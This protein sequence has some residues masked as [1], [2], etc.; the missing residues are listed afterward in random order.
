M[1]TSTSPERRDF[2]KQS[3][4][5]ALSLQFAVTRPASAASPGAS[6]TAFIR[7]ETSGEILILS[8]TLEMGQGTHTAHAMIL[9][10]ELG[11]DLS[12]VRVQTATPAPEFGR[13]GANNTRSMNS[14][15]SWGVR[16][17]HQP[18]RVVGAQAREMLLAA[19]ATRWKVP[20]NDLV[21]EGGRVRH[22]ASGRSAGFGELAGLAASEAVPANPPLRAKE[23][24]RYSGRPV[25]RLDIPAKTNGSFIYGCDLMLPEMVYACARLSPVF[26]AE[27]QDFDSTDTLRTPG[28]LQVVPLPHGAAVVAKTTWAAM[29]GAG[30]LKLRWKEATHDGLSSATISERMRAGLAADSD[31]QVAKV[32]GD[33]QAAL[34]GA[35]WRVEADYEVPFIA[36][37]AME[38]FN[39]TVRL[40]RD[41]VEVWGPFQIQDRQ[42]ATVARAAG[43]APEQV[44]LHTTPAGGAFGRRFDD[45]E[46]PA[47]IAVARALGPGRPVKYFWRREEETHQGGY[48]P[49]QMARLRAGLDAQGKVVALQVRTCGTSILHDFVGAP[50]P[51]LDFTNVQTLGDHRYRTGAYRADW[52]KRQE[53]VPSMFW[54]AVGATQNGFFMEAFIDELAAA[55]GKD[56][57]QLR[58]ELLSHDARALR[59]IDTAAERA[60][61]GSA[62]PPGRARGFAFVESYG[63]LCAQAIEVSIES[64]RPRVHHVTCVLDCGSVVMPDGVRSQIEG[65]VIQALSATLAE[66]ITIERGRAQQSNFHDYPVLRIGQA[67]FTI[68][69]YALES[70][71]PIGG[72]GEP[73]VPPLAPALVNAVSTLLGR[74]IRKLPLSESFV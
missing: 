16:Y 63:S 60:R 67:R 4:A 71:E 24:L 43:V 7:I 27:L 36:H 47:A 40:Q 6:L 19:A 54:R 35:A 20:A 2:L 52:V 68:D 74:R 34:A 21:A 56:S 9:A 51:A 38:T 62:L 33:V 66:K 29:Q 18:L 31:A 12:R 3:A 46:L 8:P 26:R 28:V 1:N 57:V 13:I 61:W 15:G 64:G 23:S 10:D 14:G 5:A 59:V 48:R 55:A 17:W 45:H 50:G 58:R 41:A 39:C 32:E 53:A 65:S 30:A 70:G 44:T 37:M 42:R 11:A 49:A 72:V 69:A 22:P 73:A 25:P